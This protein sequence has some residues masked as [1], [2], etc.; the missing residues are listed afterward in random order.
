MVK[1]DN[2]HW[3]HDNYSQRMTHAQWRDI[4]LAGG[5]HVI[6]KGQMVPLVATDLG[7]GVVEVMKQ[8]PIGRELTAEMF[9]EGCGRFKELPPTIE[10]ESI[11]LIKAERERQI[12]EEGYSV[13]HDQ[14]HCCQ[15]LAL[16]AV[17]YAMPAAH[18]L[19]P[20]G[21]AP[22]WWPFGFRD[23]K[24]T[25]NDRIRELVKA[26]ALIAGEIDRVKSDMQVS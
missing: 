20:P 1:L 23:W 4:L 6:Y 9:C 19:Q 3:K 15:H 10:F 11:N 7:Y 12:N 26:G 25:P 17:C 16:A 18:R 14:N 8:L 13:A 2:G 22:R 5:D 24:P 21:M